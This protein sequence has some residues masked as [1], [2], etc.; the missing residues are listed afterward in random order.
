VRGIGELNDRRTGWQS[1]QLVTGSIVLPSSR[2]PGD[3][4]VTEFQK[5][6]LQKPRDLLPGVAS[7]S[8]SYE[9]PFFGLNEPR[10]YVVAG[11]ELPEPGREPVAHLNGVSPR[12]FETVGTR[13]IEGRVFDARDTLAAPRVVVVNQAMARGLFGNASPLG[14]RLARAGA[15]DLQGAEIVGRQRRE[16]RGAR[17]EPR[18]LALP[19]C[20]PE[21][22]RSAF[23]RGGV[24]PLPG[25]RP[26]GH[27]TLTRI[28]RSDVE[29]A[30]RRGACQ[31]RAGHRE[32]PPLCLGLPRLPALR[33]R[34]RTGAAHLRVRS[35]SRWGTV[36]R[37]H[38]RPSSERKLPPG[39]AIG[40]WA[41]SASR[42]SSHGLPEHS[43]DERTRARRVTPFIDRP[44]ACYLPREAPRA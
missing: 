27:A 24:A 33:H 29:R 19:A 37:H 40:L 22:R 2:Y 1:D 10:K 41:P 26:H 7:A 39:S 31:L 36:R 12:Y 9:M 14:K 43:H 42:A 15:Q 32:P 38:V 23:A 4:E 30:N 8:F 20:G 35:A 3:D 6:A 5:K 16:V 13:L 11:R 18:G 28:C 21:P 25:E 44:V 17:R 34:R